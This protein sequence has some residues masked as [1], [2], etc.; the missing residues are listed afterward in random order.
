MCRARSTSSSSGTSW[1]CRESVPMSSTAPDSWSCLNFRASVGRATRRHLEVREPIGVRERAPDVRD[2]RIRQ[3]H[4]PRGIVELLRVVADV[5]VV[6]QPLDR[7]RPE[8]RTRALRARFALAA[9][10][11][12]LPDTPAPR[13]FRC[14]R[15]C[16]RR[17]PARVE[18]P[19]VDASARPP[20]GSP[21]APRPRPRAP[22]PSSSGPDRSA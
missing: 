17:R 3:A 18:S 15:S 2:D 22:P 9:A 16:R 12:R 4:L 1:V 6:E 21:C 20:A 8:E 13:P 5:L 10:S 19:R 14:A 11:S 7:R